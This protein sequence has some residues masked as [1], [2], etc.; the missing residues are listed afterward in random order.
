MKKV[1][2]LQFSFCIGLFVSAQVSFTVIEPISIAGAYDFTSNGDAADWGLADLNNPADAVQDTVVIAEDGTPGINAQ[3]IPHSNEACSPLTNNVTGKIV[4]VYRY[5]GVS[6]NDCYI[7]TKILHAQNAGAVG[8]IVVN[9]VDGVYA[10]SGFPDGMSTSI[11]FAFI[12]K[13]DGALI[14]SKIENGETVVAFIGN[15]LGL[16]GDDIGIKKM[17]TLRPQNTA[18]AALTTQAQNEYGFDVG[19]TIYNYGTNNQ[20]TVNITATVV[21]PNGTWTQ[22]AGPFS[23][24]P[25]DSIDVYTGGTNSIPAYSM[26]NYPAGSYSLSYEV[27]LGA[28]SD[29]ASYDD[30]L[31]YDFHIS[32]S[33]ISYSFID[34]ATNLPMVSSSWRPG[35][36]ATSWEACITYKDAN[37][38]RLGLQ[39]LYFSAAAGTNDLT[40]EEISLTLYEWND[41]FAD[42]NDANFGFSNLNPISYGYY[43]Y[44][45]DL[46]EVVV[47]QGFDTPTQLVDDQRYL[48]CIGNSNANVWL[49]FGRD[50]NYFANINHYLQPVG[51]VSDGAEYY[52]LG[53]GEDKTPLITMKVFDA[54]EMSVIEKEDVSLKLYPNP[55]QDVLNIES[56]ASVEVILFDLLGHVVKNQL[57]SS[58]INSVHIE[59]LEKGLY[60]VKIDGKTIGSFVKN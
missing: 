45:S 34:P 54:N 14:R 36:G 8:V 44:P 60:F 18:T 17:T 29:E 5:D 42:L 6:T 12:G 52:A 1:F 28:I 56:I 23:I 33:L 4:M 16:F 50:A 10:Y 15:K 26:T 27:D 2:L 38:S 21:G 55:A 39:G 59:S 19:A 7:S 3:G 53:F 13:S 9:R 24:L 40:G 25:G 31:G 46:D 41:V 43:Y 22:S 20:S 48:V 37:A 35:G 51:P 47:Y 30:S 58:G 49:G 32:D 11:P 57:L